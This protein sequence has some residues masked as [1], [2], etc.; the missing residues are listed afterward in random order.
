MRILWIPQISSK[1]VDG[2]ILLNKDSNISVLRNLIGTEFVDANKI[3]IAFE[4]RENECIIDNELKEN[5]ELC[6]DSTHKFTNA[7]LERMHFNVDYFGWF[8]DNKEFDVIFTNEPTK[9]IPLKQIFKTTPVVCYN[10]WLAIKNMPWL[11][12]RQYEGMAAA[13][14]CFVNSDYVGKCVEE[15]Y[16]GN[17]CMPRINFVKA[18]PSFTGEILPV[19]KLESKPAFIYNHRLSSDPYYA[20]AFDSL[21]RICD[22]LE[23]RCGEDKMPIIYFTNPSGKDFKFDRPYFKEIHLESQQEYKDFLKSNKIRGHLNTFFDSEGMWSMSTVDC[24]AAGNP[25]ILPKKYGYAEI[26]EDSYYGYVGSY[27]EF[28]NKMQE[29]IEHPEASEKY[30]NYYIRNHTNEAIGKLMNDTLKMIV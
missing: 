10:H 8:K 28:A 19:G 1:S 11:A 17:S 30:D 7:M 15:F 13:D 26:F 9:V 20:N 25:C 12:L 4:F 14:C 22:M 3:T 6:F 27:F 29:L 16:M 18:Q 23:K 24:A 21:C 2:N 5:F